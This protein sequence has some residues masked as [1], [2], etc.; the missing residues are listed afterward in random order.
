M[1]DTKDL[2]NESYVDLELMN[3][4]THGRS[5]SGTAVLKIAAPTFEESWTLE[6]RVTGSTIAEMKQKAAE[7]FKTALQLALDSLS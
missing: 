3:V 1:P 7:K 6:M 2:S 5:A 4:T